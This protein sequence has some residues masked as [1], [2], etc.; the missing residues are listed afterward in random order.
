MRERIQWPELATL[1]I[2]YPVFSSYVVFNHGPS[3]R[4]IK[5]AEALSED[6]L[7]AAALIWLLRKSTDDDVVSAALQSLAGL[8]RDFCAMDVLR[9]EDTISMVEQAFQDCFYKDTTVDLQ[10][11][12]LDPDG[13]ELYCRA[14]INLTRG[15]MEQ[16]PLELIEPLWVLQ[17][18]TRDFPDAAAVASCAVALSSFESHVSQ[19][20]LLAY[21]AKCTAGEIQLSSTTQCCL[22]DSVTE[23]LVLWEM[24]A[25]V[26]EETRLRAIPT[27]LR[28]LNLTG[29]LPMSNLR[30]SAALAL[31]AVVRGP[32]NLVDYRNEESRRADYC[33]LAMESLS[34][35]VDNP[36]RFV[37]Q[38]ALMKITAHELC[39]LAASIVV[40]SERFPQQLR[41]VARSS[42]SK[43]YVDGR[44]GV[45]L[46]SDAVLSDVLH[47]LYPPLRVPE[48]QRPIFVTTL[49]ET[50]EISSHPDI[51]HWSI[52]LL[53]IL[54][55]SCSVE[56]ANAFAENN[57]IN[58]VLRATKAGLVDGRRLQIDS[59]RTLCAFIGSVSQTTLEA[60][61]ST[62]A[63]ALD[64][65]QDFDLIFKSAFFDTLISV[66]AERRWWVFEVSG[67]WMPALVK[68]CRVRPEEDVWRNVIKVFR[69]FAERNV[70]EDGCAE[71]LA[72]LDVMVHL[73]QC[74]AASS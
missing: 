29:D 48:Q 37:V 36:E 1:G 44:I 15:T 56:V 22:L 65:S 73:C 21:L 12:I 52:R 46:V 55:T 20:E 33:E 59:L 66:V 26:I 16:W 32:V 43:L 53:E 39:R 24:P 28:I 68:L 11:H 13:A 69:D 63:K 60:A 31:Y 49:C 25:A 34:V 62:N 5:S 57:G 67:H 3:H 58:A 4:T 23:C 61:S 30:S 54:L 14:W 9:D 10:W 6:A 7:D 8:P 18:C 50:L 35:L 41:Q 71:T 40:Q 47:L 27:L 19:W 45:G 42:L 64:T 51:M 72:H 2:P 70:G 38:D 74:G 17:D